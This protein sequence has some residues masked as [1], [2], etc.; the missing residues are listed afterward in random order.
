MLTIFKYAYAENYT[1]FGQFNV[2][3]IAIGILSP[4]TKATLANLTYIYCLLII[5]KSVSLYT[6]WVHYI[7]SRF[8]PL[9]L[10]RGGSKTVVTGGIRGNAPTTFFVARKVRF[11]YNNKKKN[12]SP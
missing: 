9:S 6:C 7:F 2:I 4:I 8:V 12:L 11:K 5:C 3:E 1:Q 10:C